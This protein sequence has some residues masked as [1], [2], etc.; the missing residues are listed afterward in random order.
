MEIKC[1]ADC[2]NTIPT[3]GSWF[4]KEWGYLHPGRT[5]LQVQAELEGSL[6]RDKIPFTFVMQNDSVPVATASVVECDMETRREYSPWLASVYVHESERKKGLGKE[7][8]AEAMKRAYGLGYREIYLFTPSQEKWY[9]KMGYDTISQER[10]LGEM[11]TVMH[12]NLG[13]S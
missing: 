6:N 9:R 8:V 7:V 4:H 5:L 1:L 10:Y 13:A 2:P 3:L 11:V 12:S